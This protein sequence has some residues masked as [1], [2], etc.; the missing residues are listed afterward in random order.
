LPAM[1]EAAFGRALMSRPVQGYLANQLAAGGGELPALLTNA[2]LSPQ[3]L[4]EHG[5]LVGRQTR[6]AYP[7]GDPRWREENQ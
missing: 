5:G 3:L 7:P 4:A 1:A 6:G 2:L